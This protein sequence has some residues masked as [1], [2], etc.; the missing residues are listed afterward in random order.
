VSRKTP[1]ARKR[2]FSTLKIILSPLD[3]LVDFTLTE[4]DTATNFYPR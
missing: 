2:R 3:H 4:P 1:F